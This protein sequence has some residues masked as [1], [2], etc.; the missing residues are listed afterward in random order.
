[1]GPGGRR[2]DSLYVAGYALAG[3]DIGY[4]FRHYSHE[5]NNKLGVVPASSRDP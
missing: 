3:D 1:M 2:D 4:C 5:R